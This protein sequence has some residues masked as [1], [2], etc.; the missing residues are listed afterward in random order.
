MNYE[1]TEEMKERMFFQGPILKF[2]LY[3]RLDF[4]PTSIILC[5]NRCQKLKCSIERAQKR[6]HCHDTF[7]G[8]LTDLTE[9]SGFR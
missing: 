6:T 2:A 4:L 8:I 5:V 7:R 9:T 1:E 3:I